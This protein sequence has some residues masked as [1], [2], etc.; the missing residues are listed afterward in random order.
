[1]KQYSIDKTYSLLRNRMED[2][3]K[4]NYLGKND[5]LR[6]MC[7][8]ILADSLCQ[9][10][11]IEANPEYVSVKNGISE[12]TVLTY[13]KPSLV[14]MCEKKL[15]VI[16]TP[17]VHQIKA[18]EEYHNGKDLFV[19][20]GTGS[21][22][23]EC[24]MWPMISS[25]MNERSNNPDSWSVRG[26]RALILYPMNALVSDQLS[27]LRKMIGDENGEFHKI[28]DEL[29]ADARYPQF[30]MYT[31]RTPYP[32]ENNEK[33]NKELASTLDKGLVKID[34][35][36]KESLIDDGKYPSKYD[37]ESFIASVREGKHFTDKRDAEMITRQ[38][39][40]NN[41]PDILV[42]NY[43]M[44]QYM[45]I[46]PIEQPIWNSTKEWLDADRSNKILFIIDEAH[47]YKGA[48]GGEVALLIRRFMNKLGIDRSRLRFILT[49]ASVPKNKKED[50][51]KFACDL[52]ASEYTKSN[53]VIITGEQE[54]VDDSHALSHS[55]D[56]LSRFY[57]EQMELSKDT[58]Q[59]ICKALKFDMQNCDWESDDDVAYRL[60]DNL[61]NCQPMLKILKQCRGNATKLTE[62]AHIAYPNDDEAEAERALNVL[63]ALATTAKKRNGQAFFPARM[64][65]F[66]KGI[67][68]LYGCV[69]PECSE[70][71]K[72]I[73]IGKIYTYRRSACSCGGKVFELY[74]DRSCGTL[75]L[76][77]YYDRTKCDCIWN[78]KG[79][80]DEKQF[81]SVSLY[82][83][84]SKEPPRNSSVHWMNVKTGRLFSDDTHAGESGYVKVCLPKPTANSKFDKAENISLAF[85]KCPHCDKN[86]LHVTDFS[87]KGNEPFFHLV[88][89]QLHIQPPTMT[90]KKDIERTPNEGRKV[91][92]FSDSRQTAATLAK[93]LT[94]AADDEA[95]KK[96]IPIAA[97]NLMDWCEENDEKPSLKYLY[98]FLLEVCYKYNLKLFYGKDEEAFNRDIAKFKSEYEDEPDDFD[99]YEFMDDEISPKL[100]GLYYSQLLTQFCS[101]FRSFVDLAVCWLS[102][103]D[104]AITTLIKKIKKTD[105][106]ISKK[107]LTQLLCAWINEALTDSYSLDNSIVLDIRRN[108]TK[109]SR[110]GLDSD[111][112]LNKF[113]KL[114]KEKYDDESIKKLAELIDN[115]F[116][117]ISQEDDRKYINPA[118]VTITVGDE[119]SWYKCERCGSV[120]PFS[121]YGKCARCCKGNVHLMDSQELQGLSFWRE[122]VIQALNGEY[123]HITGIN[124][125][126]HTAQL[127]HK[128]QRQTMWSTTEDI[129]RRF[130]NVYIDE[131]DKPVDILSSTT[132]M[133]VGIDIGSLTAVGLRNIPPMR[134]NYQQRA[135]RAGRRGASIST[136]VTYVENGP[137]DNYYYEHPEAIISGDPRTP[138]IDNNNQK[139]SQRHLN[140]ICVTDAFEVLGLDINTLPIGTFF[141]RYYD[142]FLSALRKWSLSDHQKQIL[143]PDGIS[144]DKEVIMHDIIADIDEIKDD[145]HAFPENYKNESYNAEENNDQSVLD[146]LLSKGIFPTYSFPRNVVGF[147]IDSSKGDKL[148]QRPDRGL[149]I[150]ISEYAP[151]RIVVVNKKTYRSGGIYSFYSK[152]RNLYEA[153]KPYFEGNNSYHKSVYS[154]DN[155][156]CNWFGTEKPKDNKCPFCHSSD[157]STHTLLV[158]WG[159]APENARSL[160]ESE[161][162]NDFSYAELPCY[163]I[164]PSE[165]ELI[166]SD[167][168]KML[169]Y[170]RKENQPL[171]IMNK[172]PQSD[173]FTV[174][175]K[176][177]AAVAG[178]DV[179]AL[180]KIGR[181]YVPI[182]KK[183]Y[184]CSHVA[185]NVFLGDTFI[186]DLALLEIKLDPAKINVFDIK[187]WL[188]SATVTLAEAI[189][190][191]ASRLLD[192]EYS[193][194]SCGYRYRYNTNE[195]F[196]DIFVYDS[197]S[198]GAGYS[199]G[200]VNNIDMLLAET[201]NVLSSCPSNCEDTCHNCLSN[202]QNKRNQHIMNRFNALQLLD[203][204]ENGSLARGI[205]EK[206]QERLVS[207]VNEWLKIDGRYSII[208]EHDAL[209]VVGQSI[210]RKLYIYPAMWNEKSGSIP[211]D[212][213][214]IPDV[215]LKKSM[216]E[217][218]SIIM[219]GIK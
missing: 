80:S 29:R 20:T 213:I 35:A 168:F 25:I 121:L 169:K 159:F 24:F 47:M 205:A 82:L 126:E 133:E 130:K 48:A 151:G 18:L 122:P 136:I 157:I 86:N 69:N 46:R 176:C 53:F 76:K 179:D 39:I 27:R 49:S 155:S 100:P 1:M 156:A 192:I 127:S 11:Y 146:V 63:L 172:G 198:S 129:E 115:E 32:G 108:L 118:K 158:P 99:Y 101:N 208:S 92:L 167:K 214:A 61:Y 8:D 91:L 55:A 203:W 34:P 142:D 14:A 132:T 180:K 218:V 215:K 37:L 138:W 75:F 195:V 143:L 64:H 84:L 204:T 26:V 60:T 41:C 194:L 207:G 50:V 2:Y 4:T 140:V 183:G 73:G 185:E 114:L 174:C 28:C 102:P 58:I 209:Y 148:E 88:S 116:L 93:D 31:G 160:P 178:D 107:E 173:G 22:K 186:T 125:E 78:E 21:G 98:V 16:D 182:S 219:N 97:R 15:K 57:K 71:N 111:K 191:A 90:D 134:E 106:E 81:V 147:N 96:A 117:Q 52:S 154:C 145:Y 10:P 206:E 211:E 131:N 119:H 45:L 43:S 104:R 137:H 85:N 199:Y 170:V 54:S 6:A 112:L 144:F 89:E 162:E 77:G 103:T 66:F 30:G 184:P 163:S 56:V 152:Y 44:L 105:I 161:S 181:P 165:D 40:I 135:G 110:F 95:I 42:T 62:L 17:Y 87:T 212:C 196:A 128:D 113:E 216:P 5:E 83:P 200:V 3:I 164:T 193:E 171:L 7:K 19:A 59:Q 33:R 123:S 217:A 210:K 153:A 150:A 109:Y 124:T 68:G 139:L 190:L 94:K 74:N 202:Y 201:R 23:T 175:Q 65:M 38:E 189:L 197:L 51:E 187:L 12:N 188:E 67:S 79:L 149:N 177:G 166:S 13:E 70:Y 120:F 36:A 9:I 141:E 72:K